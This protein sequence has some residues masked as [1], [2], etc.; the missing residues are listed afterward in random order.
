MNIYKNGDEFSNMKQVQ[1]TYKKLIIANGSES[2][3]KKGYKENLNVQIHHH[4]LSYIS[5]GIPTSFLLKY[6]YVL[7]QP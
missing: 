5:R 3:G 2:K 6:L 1:K 7:P 4:N